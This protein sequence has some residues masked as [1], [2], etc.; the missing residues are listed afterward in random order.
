MIKTRVVDVP[1][2]GNDNRYHYAYMIV[3]DL[4]Q[5]YY[6]GVHTSDQY[7]DKYKGSGSRLKMA[8]KKYGSANFTKYILRF[9]NDIQTML[10]Y[11]ESVVDENKIN[12]NE[13]YNLIP[14]GGELDSVGK[15]VVKDKD[16]NT[17]AVAVN[18]PRINK[19]LIPINKGMVTVRDQNNKTLRVS[20]DDPRLETGELIYE[21]KGYVSVIDQNGRGF[22][23]RKDD[24]RW[25][26]GELKHSL[27]GRVVVEDNNGNRISIK[28]DDPR[29][30]TGEYKYMTTDRITVRDK[31]GN[32]MSVSVKD[33]RIQTGELVSVNKNR[34]YINNGTEQKMVY[35]EDIQKYLDDGWKIGMT[36]KGC[37]WVNKNGQG[38]VI[39]KESLQKYLDDGWVRGQGLTKPKTGRPKKIN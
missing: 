21:G 13:C 2:L 8:Y 29:L 20:K 19:T 5:H 18:D 9:F 6:V 33:P 15:C 12:D 17:L 3:N 39:P 34:I 38:K 11:E 24:P 16:G 14:G 25:L 23:V 31:F 35:K 26:L 28:K 1:F 4:N 10:K 36:K 7:L 27:T 37:V 32:T 22:R 30:E